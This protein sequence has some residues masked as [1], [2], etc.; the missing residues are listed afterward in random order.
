MSIDEERLAAVKRAYDEY[1]S[2]LFGDKV[3]DVRVRESVASAIL[4]AAKASRCYW[5]HMASHTGSP[6][7]T[8]MQQRKILVRNETNILEK[9][10]TAKA[11]GSG[12]FA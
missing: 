2:D 6:T 8:L 7:S 5:E 3:P 9:N 4:L 1:L 10:H 12:W 11:I